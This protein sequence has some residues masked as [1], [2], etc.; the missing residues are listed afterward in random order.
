MDPELIIPNLHKDIQ[1]YSAS[2]QIDMFMF[3]GQISRDSAD[4]FIDLV[5]AEKKH[6]ELVLTI[7]TPGGDP[8]AAY[9]IAAFLKRTYGEK[10]DLF[11]PSY[12][13]S[14]GTLIALAA[15]NLIFGKFGELG[16]L[17]VQLIKEDDQSRTSGLSLLQAL[18][19]L[20]NLSSNVFTQSFKTIL[21]DVDE[22]ISYRLAGEFS[23]QLI[24]ATVGPILANVDPIRLGEIMRS[25]NIAN[26]YGKRL[27]CEDEIVSKLVIG[28]DDHGIVIDEDEA[29]SIGFHILNAN[30]LE[31]AI[32]SNL[33]KLFRM[34]L[35]KNHLVNLTTC[36]NFE[37]TNESQQNDAADERSV[38]ED[39]PSES[40][41]T[42][43]IDRKRAKK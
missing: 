1:E 8:H 5:E 36:F 22:F 11:I 34:E 33:S 14:A 16:P 37:N 4:R 13:K 29:R 30:P 17:D 18:Y 39:V 24:K 31:Q 43:R 26:H 6:K 15:R 38:V 21:K 9:R 25:N 41:D 19:F 10:F 23:S 42:T 35:I 27:E 32:I 2:R 40:E 7:I 12:C 3:T 20:Q 28:Y